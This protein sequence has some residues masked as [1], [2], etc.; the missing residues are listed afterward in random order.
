MWPTLRLRHA[1]PTLRSRSPASRGRT[2]SRLPA[3]RCARSH[4]TSNHNREEVMPMPPD[5]QIQVPSEAIEG[6]EGAAALPASSG[7]LKTT[8]AFCEKWVAATQAQYQNRLRNIK[9]MPEATPHP[10]PQC[11]GTYWCSKPPPST[12]DDDRAMPY[13][14]KLLIAVIIGFGFM[15]ATVLFARAEE[16]MPFPRRDGNCPSGYYRSEE[17]R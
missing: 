17:R 7:D 15:V 10:C 3:R 12:D 16:A 4:R 5:P 13:A 14:L 2:R 1:A 9:L 6:G 8:C 11:G